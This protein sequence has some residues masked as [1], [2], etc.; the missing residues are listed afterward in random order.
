MPI[1][2]FPGTSLGIAQVGR[3]S[4]REVKQLAVTQLQINEAR[5]LPRSIELQKLFVSYYVTSVYKIEV[6]P[7]FYFTQTPIYS[8]TQD[9][10]E[11]TRAIHLHLKK[12]KTFLKAVSTFLILASAEVC[13][14]EF[15]P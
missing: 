12:K 9:Y 10:F 6:C 7:S 13:S 11:I 3:L 1:I 4:L 14:A 8:V 15:S 5:M 2:C